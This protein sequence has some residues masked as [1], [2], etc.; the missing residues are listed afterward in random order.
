MAGYRALQT[1]LANWSE[2]I[3]EFP[4]ALDREKVPYVSFSKVACVEF[5]GYRYLLEYV[6]A[7]TSIARA[8]L[9]RQ[10]PGV[11]RDGCQLVPQPGPRPAG[12][13]GQ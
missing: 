6:K 3:G 2:T 7:Q 8:G 11:S 10:G 5:C 12:R 9:L 13:R 4:E 1:R